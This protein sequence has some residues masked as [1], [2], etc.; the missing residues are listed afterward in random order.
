MLG[1]FSIGNMNFNQLKGAPYVNNWRKARSRELH[2][3]ELRSVR[4]FG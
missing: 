3:Y 1:S 4:L 2:L